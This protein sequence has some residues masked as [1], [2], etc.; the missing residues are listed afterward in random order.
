[1]QCS[2]GI[3]KRDGERIKRDIDV[4]VTCEQG[5]PILANEVEEVEG[6]IRAPIEVK[7]AVQVLRL[8]RASVL[9]V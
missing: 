1:M 9:G 6:S 4:V 5:V 3:E 8:A 2:D 7:Y